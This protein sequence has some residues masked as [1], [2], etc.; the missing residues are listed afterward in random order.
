MSNFNFLS[1][2]PE[3]QANAQQAEAVSI[4]TRA[5]SPLLKK[6]A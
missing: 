6:A 5:R 2:W 4:A 1:E 3:L